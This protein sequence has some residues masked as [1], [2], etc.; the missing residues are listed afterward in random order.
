MS[1]VTRAKSPSGS[2]RTSVRG[3]VVGV[4]IRQA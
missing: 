1:I 3:A 4:A 2:T